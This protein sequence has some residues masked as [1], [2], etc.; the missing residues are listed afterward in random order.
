MSVPGVGPII[1][2]AMVAA[3]GL[4]VGSPK[5]V[6]L[7]LGW[8]CPQTDLDRRQHYPGQDIQAWQSLAARH[9]RPGGMGRAD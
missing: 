8:A 9:V 2:S 6:T 4:E 1:F 5:A 7:P 3:I